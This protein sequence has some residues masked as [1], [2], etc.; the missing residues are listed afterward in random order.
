[1]RIMQHASIDV[2][3]M[4]GGI[5]RWVETESP[6]Q[7][8][9]AVNRMIDLVQS[10][11]SGLPVKVERIAGRNGFADNLVVR[12]TAAGE[13]PGV[14]ILSH[15]DTVHPIGTLAGPLPF[16][17]DGDTLYGPVRLD[18][19]GGAYLALEAFR[20]VAKA[21]SAKLPVT[22]VFTPDEEVGSPSSRHLLEAEAHS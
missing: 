8:T 6:T 14:L 2:A 11:V 1:M 16:R 12:N 21:K 3:A 9:A 17:R 13:G 4:I 7:S 15:I 18:M 22:F 5:Q 10:D 19:K 20:Q